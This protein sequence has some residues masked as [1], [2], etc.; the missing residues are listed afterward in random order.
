MSLH[1]DEFSASSTARPTSR[2]SWVE[3]RLA[4]VAEA[5]TR[6][7]AD[8]M[9][10]LIKD[11]PE[12]DD[13][14]TIRLIYEDLCERR[15]RGEE[16]TTREVIERYP[17]FR[18]E[19]A[20]LL[21]F[22]R[23]VR[24]GSPTVEFPEVNEQ[25]GTFS[26][27]DELGRGASGRAY[28]A[29][30]GGLADR[31]VVLK[32]QPIDQ[33]EHLRLAQLQN[34][35]VIPLFSEHAFPDRGLR[36]LCMPYMGGVSF[37]RLLQ[38][39]A[40]IPVQERTG[41]HLLDS[42]ERLQPRKLEHH[43]FGSPCRLFLK[44]ESWT[45]AVCWIA[46]CLADALAAAHSRGL[47]HM[48]LKPSNILIAGDG[49]PLLLDFHLARRPLQPRENVAGRLGGTTGWMSPEQ[50]R[51]FEAA[52]IGQPVPG[53]VDG[54]CD[55]YALGLL[56][57]TALD[58]RKDPVE[59]LTPWRPINPRV[60]PGLADIVRRCL[61]IDPER[62]YASAESLADDLRRHLDDLPL[63]EVPNRSTRERWGKW[64]RRRPGA[65]ARLIVG[66]VGIGTILATL[67]ILGFD[68]RRRLV[69]A[70]ESLAVGRSLMA[71]QRHAEA[72]ATF[73]R[74]LSRIG[75]RPDG[76]RAGIL[77]ENLDLARLG[78][79]ADE[80]HRLA[81]S[82]RFRF[83]IDPPDVSTARMLA[84][85]VPP[86]WKVRERLLDWASKSG[87]VSLR[88]RVRT[89][90]LELAS[91]SADARIRNATD[92]QKT[93]EQTE[94]LALLE[95]AEK[96]CGRSPS[97]HRQIQ[98]IRHDLNRSEIAGSGDEPTLKDAW[99]CY[100]LG[101][102]HLRSGRLVEA[103]DQFEKASRER[104][105]DFWPCFY[106]GLCAYQLG[107]FDEAE[108]AFRVCEA[109]SP[110]S[111]ECSHNHALALEAKDRFDDALAAYSRAVRIDAKLAS[112][113]LNR[114]RLNFLRKDYDA[115]IVD[116]HEAIRWAYEP[117]IRQKAEE[118]LKIAM[119]K[120][121]DGL[122]GR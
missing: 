79:Q 83:G 64:R 48:D 117:S 86:I 20:M 114:G 115:A 92:V 95:D 2:T 73:T 105:Q 50:T 3:D 46:A 107:R 44:G 5:R 31:L 85:I 17:Q 30:E 91:I 40:S 60:S 1:H 68:H 54:R 58:G 80:L 74:G 47:I 39:L 12:W 16:A 104:P 99:E 72:I 42:L 32:V 119:T 82:V 13:E 56:L 67:A 94:A 120:K 6:G 49:L 103:M 51:A 25:L 122:P 116:Y 93:H 10:F 27:V 63:K 19:L 24:A 57:A 112:A 108:T 45:R 21:D 87:D 62:R 78:Q 41:S 75:E 113:R 38:D 89:D 35:H 110:T 11:H 84:R 65:L 55:I 14:T 29:T 7:A 22:D 100:D 88:E 52:T 37:D 61:S 53:S 90:L 28:L 18:E 43:D 34:T 81:E 59:W 4:E 76:G 36:A 66:S 98:A 70:D 109:L 101:R 97:L 26:L 33:D 9:G 102:F 96:T 23:L 111:A 121:N 71:R 106:L 69:D 77:R 8:P 15:E 118:S